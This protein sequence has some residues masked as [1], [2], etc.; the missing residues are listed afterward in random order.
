MLYMQL[1]EVNSYCDF[2]KGI[3]CTY[4]L[5]FTGGGVMECDLLVDEFSWV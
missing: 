2:A 5:D 3:D 4:V 1:N